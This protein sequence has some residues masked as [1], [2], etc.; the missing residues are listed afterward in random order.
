MRI[1]ISREAAQNPA[2]YTA[3]AAP[4]IS[5]SNRYNTVCGEDNRY[6]ESPPS[7]PITLSMQMNSTLPLNHNLEDK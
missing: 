3:N 2:G 6:N 5:L 7:S 4:D 1:T